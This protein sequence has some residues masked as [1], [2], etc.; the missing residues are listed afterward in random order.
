MITYKTL[1]DRI[2]RMN[3]EINLQMLFESLQE[4]AESDIRIG[5]TCLQ[6]WFKGVFNETEEES[7]LTTL[8]LLLEAVRSSIKAH[9]IINLNLLIDEQSFIGIR[10]VPTEIK[11]TEQSIIIHGENSAGAVVSAEI[12]YEHIT[13]AVLDNESTDFLVGVIKEKPERVCSLVWS[14]CW[15]GYSVLDR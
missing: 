12:H 4:F 2:K 5:I 8:G 1:T 11:L 3:A 6:N 13:E 7:T 14:M 10:F 9:R 15:H